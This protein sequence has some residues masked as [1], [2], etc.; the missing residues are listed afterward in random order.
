MVGDALG[1]AVESLTGSAIKEKYGVLR[2]MVGSGAQGKE[3]GATSDDTEM[4]LAVAEGLLAD[5]VFPVREIGHLF[6]SWYLA[7]PAGVGTTTRA[8]LENYR[9]TGNWKQAARLAAQSINKADSNGGL[10]RTLPVTLGY[11]YN[12]DLMASRSM[13]VAF[14]THYSDEGAACCIMY[15]YLVYLAIFQPAEKR[16]MVTTA[17]QYTNEQC[18]RLFINPS[19]F[20]WYII[21]SLQPGLEPVPPGEGVLET[22][23]AA[24]QCFLAGS[25]F[26]E[27]LVE[28]VNRGG[29]TDTG[30]T[31]AGGLA[32]S[33]YGY[34]SIPQRWI[35]PLK[36]RERLER[37]V[38]KFYV[39]YQQRIKKIGRAS[40]RERV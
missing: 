9:R 23:A 8:S 6:W 16:A 2:D 21:K 26:E 39:L 31:V 29:D 33:F 12:P 11:W 37:V 15:N 34:D 4:M 5:P 20:F 3:P 22:L 28:M 14:M 27:I 40:C 7:N 38:D 10:M 36:N 19:R 32:G 24:V 18:K 35:E 25:D 1:G 30:G 13:E 17:F